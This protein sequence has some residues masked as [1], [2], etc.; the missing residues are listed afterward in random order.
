[1][2]EFSEAGVWSG[3]PRPPFDVGSIVP[4][5]KDFLQAMATRRKRLALVP[6]VVDPS[7]LGRLVDLGVAA[8][9]C[10]E[11][12]AAMRELA[13]GPLAVLALQPVVENDDVLA[14]RAHGADAIVVPAGAPDTLAKT[15]RSTRMV[16][17]F[18]ARDETEARR[19]I[20]AGAKGLLVVVD[21][22]AD[23]VVITAALPA[24]T[25]VLA[26]LL[27]D[28]DVPTLRALLGRVDAVVVDT[29]LASTSEFASLQAEV[30]PG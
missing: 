8:V 13:A 22:A 20:D 28:A 23:L 27:R 26:R 19:A 17:L 4:S 18:L 16:P 5:T 7:E 11:A 21:S 30:D 10:D 1:V 9:A 12:G 3:M 24:T 15:T 14:A 6:R 2:G 25:R 29:A